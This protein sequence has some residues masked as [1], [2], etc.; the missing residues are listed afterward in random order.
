MASKTE[1]SFGKYK[2]NTYDYVK[3][4]DVAYCNWALKQMNVSTTLR[5]FQQWLKTKGR[6]VTCECCN[7]NG[8]IYA[9]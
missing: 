8:L 2:G 1:I 3:K 7:G 5:H 4:N 9:V 6:K